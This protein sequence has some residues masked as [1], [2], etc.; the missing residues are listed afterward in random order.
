VVSAHISLRIKFLFLLWII[1]R[2]T[3][4]AAVSAT[5]AWCILYSFSKVLWPECFAVCLAIHLVWDLSLVKYVRTHTRQDCF[6][7][8]RLESISV[9]LSILQALIF[10]L[11][12]T[13]AVIAFLSLAEVY[14]GLETHWLHTFLLVTCVIYT[15]SRGRGKRRIALRVNDFSQSQPGLRKDRTPSDP[16]FAWNVVVEQPPRK[17]RVVSREEYSSNAARS[18]PPSGKSSRG[19]RVIDV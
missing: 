14:T 15:L 7:Y 12:P 16:E 9:V 1:I 18:A 2:G 6:L 10:S 17:Q 19:G 11:L 4:D 3:F 13:I 5:T 8:L